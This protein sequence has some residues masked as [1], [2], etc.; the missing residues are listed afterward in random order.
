MTVSTPHIRLITEDNK[1]I[2][3]TN[4]INYLYRN[5]NSNRMLFIIRQKGLER[6][7]GIIDYVFKLL[8]KKRYM[9]IESGLCNIAN[10]NK[11]VTELYPTKINNKDIQKTIKE[12]NGKKLF[13]IITNYQNYRMCSKHIKKKMRL[14]YPNNQ[15]KWINYFHSSDS[16]VD[17][18]KEISILKD[19]ANIS[20]DNI[21]NTYKKM[22]KNHIII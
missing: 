3:Q 19:T 4:T 22:A 9:V 12:A 1:L 10:V 20:F 14:K 6:H 16:S 21:G 2:I 18:E 15:N 11:M 5:M 13:Y 17:A 8:K 7:S